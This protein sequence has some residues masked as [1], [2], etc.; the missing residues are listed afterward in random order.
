MSPQSSQYRILSL[1]SLPWHYVNLAEKS[2]PPPNLEGKNQVV[3][4]KLNPI[5]IS[6]EKYYTTFYEF[7]IFCLFGLLGEN[8]PQSFQIYSYRDHFEKG[9]GKKQYLISDPQRNVML[10]N[11]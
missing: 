11:C 8:G 2:P 5:A 3:T 9:N 6:G 7:R 4:T 1:P 10:K